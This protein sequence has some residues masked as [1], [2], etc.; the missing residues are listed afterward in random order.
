MAE[1]QRALKEAPP[2]HQEALLL[3]KGA[4]ARAMA[5]LG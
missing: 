1:I 3:E 4:L 2:E 5:A